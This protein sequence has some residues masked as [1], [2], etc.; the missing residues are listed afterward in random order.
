MSRFIPGGAVRSEQMRRAHFR[1]TLEKS[2]EREIAHITS[3]IK[4]DISPAAVES[5]ME[6]LIA[7]GFTQAHA[8]ETVMLA[9][10]KALKTKG[11]NAR[12][13]EE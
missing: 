10:K 1:N 12:K 6:T 13:T 5:C 8:K 4:N 11:N 7:K 9:R 2:C 3:I